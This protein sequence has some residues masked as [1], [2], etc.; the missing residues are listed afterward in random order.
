MCSNEPDSYGQ[1]RLNF[2]VLRLICND[3]AEVSDVLSFALTCSTLRKGALQRRLVMSSVVLSSPE[4]VERFHKFIFADQTSRAPYLYGLTFHPYADYAPDGDPRFQSCLIAILEVATRLEYLDFPTSIGDSVCSTVAKMTTLRELVVTSGSNASPHDQYNPEAL[5]ILLTALRSPLRHLLVADYEQ[6]Q[7]SLDF[8]HSHL[9]HFAPTLEFLKFGDLSSNIFSF[10]VTTPFAAVR[11]LHISSVYQFS[12]YGMD[13][14]LRLF[15]NLDDTLF[16][17]GF[18]LRA[19]EYSGLRERNQEAQKEYTWPGLYRVTYNTPLAFT[20]ALRCPIR[21]MDIYGLVPEEARYLTEVLRDN[22]PQQ[23]LLPMALFSH[24]HLQI[25]DR[26]FPPEAADRL[27]HLV[28]FFEIDINRRRQP[29]GQSNSNFSWDQ[30]MDTFVHATKHLRRLTHLRVV[31]Y[32]HVYAPTS[33]FESESK[34]TPNQPN[35]PPEPHV[36]DE[37]FA[38]NIAHDA[39]LY[40]AAIRLLHSLPA[41]EYVLLTTCGVHRFGKPWT[42]WHSSRAWHV[43]EVVAESEDLRRDDPLDGAQTRDSTRSRSCV[44]ISGEAAE[45]VVDEEEL[46]LGQREEKMV[47]HC[48]QSALE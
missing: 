31:L 18:I 21:C 17:K 10:P 14:L 3:L 43:Q 47:S 27:T 25:V 8:L 42:Y 33:E 35:A 44:E 23:L 19:E 40:P 12:A 37:A 11:S 28:L 30:F 36:D 16:L 29:S 38:Q 46:H 26:L 6:G 1:P 39:D 41:L 48:A 13:I 9:V 32:Y 45:A 34:P 24:N 5:G 22:C 2:D 4:A 15:P 20:M 7:I